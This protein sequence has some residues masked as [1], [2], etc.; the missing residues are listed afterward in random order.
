[1]GKQIPLYDSIQSLFVFHEVAKQKSFSKAAEELYVTQPAVTKHIKGL[2]QKIGMRLIERGKAGFGLTE[3]GKILF[4]STQRIAGHLQEVEHLLGK[5]RKEHHGFLRIGTTESYSRCLMPEL[6]SEFQTRFPSIKIA[7]DVG[8]SEEIEKSLLA[9]QN[10]VALIAVT[11]ISP[12]FECVPFLKEELVLIVSPQHPLASHRSVSLRAVEGYPFIIRARGSTTRKIVTE[13]F[14][15]LGVHPSLFIEAG[16]SEFIKQWVSEGRGISVIVD[17]I[18]EEE[19]KR[20][21]VVRIPLEERFQLQV[22]LLYLKAERGN[23]AIQHFSR[24]IE[25]KREGGGKVRNL[26]IKT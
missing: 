1:M 3:A 13:A 6:L 5:L 8:S 26:Q 9:Y 22:S 25:E 16:S 12:K 24:F 18:A 4:K 15:E 2:E 20:G 19:A 21:Q 23:P 10:D 17:R 14:K 11:K 7:L